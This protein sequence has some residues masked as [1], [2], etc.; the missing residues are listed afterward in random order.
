M[1]NSNAGALAGIRVL[2]LS[3]V[4]A[5]PWCAQML[6]D[7]G[8]DIIKIERPIVG[9]DTRH[10]GPPYLQDAAGDTRQSAFFACCNRNKRS[11]TV[12][13]SKI[14]G[15]ETIRH[16]VTQCDVLVENFKVGGLKA[17]GLDHK[18][19]QALNPRLIYCSITGFGQTGPY[20]SRPGYDLLAQAM[21][22]MM[23]VNGNSFSEPKRVGVAIMDTF[24]GTFA[25]AA[26]L[27]AL[28]ARHITGKGQYIDMS[29]LDVGIASLANLTTGFLNDGNI[30]KPQGAKH[31]ALTP[32][33]NF[34]TQDGAMILAVGNDSQFEKFCDIAGRPD[35]AIDTRFSSVSLRTKHRDILIPVIEAVTKTRKTQDWVD[36][37]SRKGVPC[38][39]IYNVGQVF[40]DPQV[41]S[42]G[43]V[44]RQRRDAGDGVKIVASVASPMRL[45]ET[46]PVLR[47][48]PPSLGQHTDEV[49]EEFGV[50]VL[51]RENLRVAGAI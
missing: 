38:G 5:G 36:A 14:E 35:W 51:M 2:D 16:M 20:A 31:A 29:L 26:I 9:D 3:R 44:V 33:Q 41:L 10:W 25:A 1:E 4:L 45:S 28:Q 50:S 24:T 46:P 12:D 11:L 13:L 22:G 27:A 7:M 37:L 8:A 21:C 34:S 23:S 6:G 39:P 32:Y 18:N 40:D 42:R 47:Y 48:A 19:L 30:P 15:Q 43:I 17:Y 49:L